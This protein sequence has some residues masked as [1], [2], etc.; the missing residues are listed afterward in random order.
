MASRVQL[1]LNVSDID[2]AVEF[3]ERLFQTPPA[4]REPGYANFAI[5]DPPL[6]L[7]LIENPDATARLN[8]LGVEVFEQAAVAA[9]HERLAGQG[10]PVISEESV[11]CCYAVQD[12]IWVNDPDGAPWETYVVL[13]QSNSMGA[14]A[15]EGCACG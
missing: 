13:E 2:Q 14:C 1:A 6:K 8:H 5:S 15:D 10:L 4:K 11:D 7:V 12:K 9:A 3:Y